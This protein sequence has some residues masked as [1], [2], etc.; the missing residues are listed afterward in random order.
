MVDGSIW[1]ESWEMGTSGLRGPLFGFPR[2]GARAHLILHRLEP[3]AEQIDL[4][5]ALRQ[6]ALLVLA[7]LG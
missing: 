7:R 1:Q 2:W 3:L 6:Q 4:G 5:L